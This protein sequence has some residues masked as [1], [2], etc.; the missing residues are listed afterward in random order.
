MSGNWYVLVN[1]EEIGPLSDAQFR[2]MAV[3]GQLGPMSSV[4]KGQS[5]SWVLAKNVRGLFQQN[6][7]TNTAASQAHSPDPH[8]TPAAP[9][10]STTSDARPEPESI[11]AASSRTSRL[12][13]CPDCGASLSRNANSCPKCGRPFFRPNRVV[14][15]ALAGFLGGLGA[16]KFYLRR[17]GEALI[18]LLFCWTFIPSLF[19]LVESLQYLSMDDDTF[20]REFNSLPRLAPTPAEMSSSAIAHHFRTVAGA[21]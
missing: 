3:N 10:A 17:P 20:A 21:G 6:S 12:V 11:K 16:H 13:A 9:K 14:A 5:E 7:A 4:R 1:G 18:Y 19:A 2:E 15:I 8:S